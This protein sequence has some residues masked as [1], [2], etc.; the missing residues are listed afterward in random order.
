[1]STL[2]QR[3]TSFCHVPRLH[4]YSVQSLS[5]LRREVINARRQ[6]QS[7]GFHAPVELVATASFGVDMNDAGD[8]IGT[9]YLDTGCGSSCRLLETVVWRDGVRIVLP[10]VPGLTGITLTAINAQAWICGFAG[11][12]YTTTDAVVWKPVRTPI[13][14]VPGNLPG[15]T[16][17]TATGIDDFGR[18][19]GWSTT[20]NFPPSGAPFMWTEAGGMVN[21]STQGFPNEQSLGIILLE[22]WPRTGSGIALMT[23]A[24]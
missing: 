15:K 2:S 16:I 24:A 12:V 13:A 6:D 4:W 7:R 23:R 22:Q 14:I 5:L 10:I 11:Y 21:L 20:Q 3:D 8:V 18:V 1:M 17:S 19:V 9:S